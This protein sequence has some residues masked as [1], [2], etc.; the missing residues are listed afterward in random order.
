MKP[1]FVTFGCGSALGKKF[2][3]GEGPSREAIHGVLL[4]GALPGWSMVYEPDQF[5]GQ[6]AKHGLTQMHVGVQDFQG[7]GVSFE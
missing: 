4:S 7:S 6:P 2:V 3:K 5:K 1:F